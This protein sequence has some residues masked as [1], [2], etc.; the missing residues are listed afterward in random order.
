MQTSTHRCGNRSLSRG[1]RGVIPVSS[2][3]GC[4]RKLPQHLPNAPRT[5]VA[6]N[7]GVKVRILKRPTGTLDGMPLKRHVPGEVYDVPASVA[8]YLVMEGFALPEMRRPIRAALKKK[9]DRRAR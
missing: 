5:I 4:T 3:H 6:I 1:T 7:N 8:E 2:T 9:K